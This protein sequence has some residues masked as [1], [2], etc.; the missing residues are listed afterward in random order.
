MHWNFESS[1]IQ[2][3][4]MRNWL[5]TIL[6]KIYSARNEEKEVQKIQA[7]WQELRQNI[8][9]MYRDGLDKN[10]LSLKGRKFDIEKIKRSVAL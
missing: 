10:L 7:C 1:K 3:L 2:V 6:N 9:Q 4:G 5:M 8:R